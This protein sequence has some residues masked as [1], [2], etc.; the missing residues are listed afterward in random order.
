VFIVKRWDYLNK[1]AG[2]TVTAFDAAK[3]FSEKY[4]EKKNWLFTTSPAAPEEKLDNP[5]DK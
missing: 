3:S 1:E 4:G 2:E 5:Y